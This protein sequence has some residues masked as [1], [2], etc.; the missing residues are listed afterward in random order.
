MGTEQAQR[1]LKARRIIHRAYGID[2]RGGRADVLRYELIGADV[3]VVLLRDARDPARPVWIRA[4]RQSPTGEVRQLRRA[5][6]RV[7]DYRGIVQHLESLYTRYGS[8]DG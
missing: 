6:A 1:I 2:P 5:S 3:A 7:S 4:A 8:H